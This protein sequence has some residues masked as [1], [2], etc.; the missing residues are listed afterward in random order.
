MGPAGDRAFAALRVALWEKVHLLVRLQRSIALQD[1]DAAQMINHVRGV[2]G[3]QVREHFSPELRKLTT[4]Q[5][6]DAAALIATL[7]SVESWEQFRHAYGRS[8]LQ[9]RR[10]WSD[11]IEGI[12][13]GGKER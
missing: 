4:A 7:T 8:P 11:A 5:C 12:L 2:M 1:P 9:T 10:A 6:D 13:R 3:N